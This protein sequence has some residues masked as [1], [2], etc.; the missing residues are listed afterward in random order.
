MFV[1]RKSQKS[2]FMLHFTFHGIFENAES[3]RLRASAVKKIANCQL[4]N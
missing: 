4:S 1:K 3:R 2:F